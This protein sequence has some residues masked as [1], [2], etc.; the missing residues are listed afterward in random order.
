MNSAREEVLKL[1][2]DR[3]RNKVESIMFSINMILSNPEKEDNQVGRMS[4][5]LVELSIAEAAMKNCQILLTQCL[6]LRLRE[7]EALQKNNS[8]EEP[9][10]PEE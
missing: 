8:T 7:L 9:K 3:L 2:N 4:E 10:Q 5:L 6:E 1:S